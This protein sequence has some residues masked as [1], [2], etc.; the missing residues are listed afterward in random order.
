MVLSVEHIKKSYDREIIK[1]IS[2]K[3]ET[4]KMYV[5]K[6]ISGCGKSTFL[7]IIGGVE[8]NYEGNV[9]IDGE[10]C[11]ADKMLNS[12]GY[13][14][15]YSLL[16]SNITVLDNLKLIDSDIVKIN[17]LAQKLGV[18]K[19]LDKYPNQISGGERQRISIIRALMQNP[20]ILLMDEPTASLDGANSL[21]ISNVISQLKSSERIVIVA[22]HEEYFDNYADEILYLD[23][24]NISKIDKA[25]YR[26]D[27]SE[28]KEI[29]GDIDNILE[30]TENNKSKLNICKY[31]YRRN[32]KMFSLL[33][34]LPFVVMFL[35]LASVSTLQEN[36]QEIY[37]KTV[38][39]NYPVEGFNISR[40][41]LE[42]FE[43]KDKVRLYE[44]YY[45]E[46]NENVAYYLAPKE[47]SV[48]GIEGMIE[49]GHFP[50][51]EKEV[52][53]SNELAKSFG[54]KNIGSCVG[55]NISFA[56]KEFVVSGIL[57][58]F[59]DDE[60]GQN[61]SESFVTYLYSD[62]YY[63]RIDGKIIF[64]PYETIK[65]MATPM[66]SDSFRGVYDGLY[67]NLDVVESLRESLYSG[68]INVFDEEIMSSQSTL[69]G[70]TELLIIVVSVCFVISCIFMSSQIQIELFYRRKEIG[71]LQIF[72]LKKKK[73]KKLLFRGY[74]Y[75]MM[76][77]LLISSIIYA[78][79]SI[80]CSTL[81]DIFLLFNVV[82]MIVIIGAMVV[83][84]FGFV[85]VSICKFVR[86]NIVDLI[87]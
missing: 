82:N 19:L 81:L 69:E 32:K 53:I 1:D 46:D 17:S 18:S 78:L 70:I 71:Y 44:Y 51:D 41:E 31:T 49:F 33:S 6:G 48:L 40:S 11:K 23:Y 75:K 65:A 72:G 54:E 16:L 79:I 27:N 45:V 68:V 30:V 4:G 28:S 42:R 52:I 43:Y 10:A 63:Q 84:Y 62:I 66:E 77:A 24:G 14:F 50:V 67:N 74:L 85:Y 47:E 56:G 64:I 26:V 8:N 34:L 35:L 83:F 13:V 9:Y 37:L 25:E 36:F 73:I 7:N 5:I 80:I 21:M 76:A 86:K 39:S 29:K 38:K 22:T 59:N 87:S 20:K 61:A 3:F 15:Q 57:F 12:T 58:S 60:R 55:K 2:Y